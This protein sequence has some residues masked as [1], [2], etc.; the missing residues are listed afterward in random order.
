[1]KMKALIHHFS[2]VHHLSTCL[3]LSPIKVSRVPNS[4]PYEAS[5][6]YAIE[7]IGFDLAW[8]QDW[9]QNV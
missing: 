6:C 8:S 4:D 5:W 7:F 2:L 3:T 1:M 9:P